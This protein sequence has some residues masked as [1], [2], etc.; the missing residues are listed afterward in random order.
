MPISACR[1]ATLRAAERSYQLLYQVAGRAGRG[2]AP[3]RVYVQ[4]FLPEHPVMAALTAGDRDRFV[5]AE[6]DARRAAGM[7]PFGRLVAVILSDRDEGRVDALARDLAR[8]ARAC[9]FGPRPGAG[10]GALVGACAAVT[11]GASCSRPG[12]EVNLQG[13][14][15][16]WLAGVRIP[17]SSRVTVDVDPYS[18]L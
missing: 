6:S 18:F 2:S 12:G 9:R 11:G 7:P 1:A 5:A 17:G 15:R 3:G 13:Y 16:Q 4:T 10:A 14:V 8:A